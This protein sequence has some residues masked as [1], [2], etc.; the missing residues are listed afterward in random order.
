M[1]ADEFYL[2]DSRSYVGNDMSFW[3]KG[4]GYTTDVSKAQVYTKL[5]AVSQHESRNSDIP[6]TKAYIDS[7]TRPAVDMQYVNHNEA[8]M[9]ARKPK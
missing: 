7:K 2:Q 4:G 6:W 9:E 8:M 3:A 1:T 5:Q